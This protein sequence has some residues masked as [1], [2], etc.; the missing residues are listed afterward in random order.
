QYGK[1]V[2][3]EDIF[4]Y[5]YGIL[6]NSQYRETFANDL[7]KML[8]RL[9]LVDKPKEFKAFSDA[10]RKLADLHLNYET[11]EPYEGADVIMSSDTSEFKPYEFYRV[12]KLRFPK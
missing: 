3:K 2:T 11:V 10:G 9:P 7:Q 5:V 1:S 6:H 4:Y 12:T 8:P